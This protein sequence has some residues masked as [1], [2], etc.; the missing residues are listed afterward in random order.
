MEGQLWAGLGR[1]FDLS[2]DILLYDLT[3]T[4]FEGQCAANPMAKRG[5]SRDSRGDCPQVVI[6]LIVTTDGY[7]LGYEVFDGNTADSTT[8]QK[9]VEKVESDHGKCNRIL[10]MDLGNVSHDNLAFIR[11]R[12]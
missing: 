1:L 3:S 12:G 8:V 2:F 5:Y 11:K 4:Y 9:I 6:A 7:P 10:I